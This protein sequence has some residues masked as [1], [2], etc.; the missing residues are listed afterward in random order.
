MAKVGRGIGAKIDDNI[1]DATLYTPYDLLLRCRRALV[2]HTS[3]C[4]LA[5]GG[6]EVALGY[7]EVNTVL[8]EL[9]GAEGT[10][11]VTSII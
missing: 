9:V 3:H 4:T 7:G 8:A 10:R 1:A 5:Y 2:V 11:E 6:G